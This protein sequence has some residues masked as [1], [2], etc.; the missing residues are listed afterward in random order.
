MPINPSF[1]TDIESLEENSTGAAAASA[2]NN[3]DTVSIPTRAYHE[4]LRKLRETEQKANMMEQQ[5]SRALEDL[6]TTK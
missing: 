5:L 2:P 4:L 1:Y 3:D 6:A